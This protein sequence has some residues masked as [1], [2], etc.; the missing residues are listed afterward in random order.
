M[1]MFATPCIYLPADA[2]GPTAR[3]WLPLNPAYGLI[4]NFRATV[5]GSELDPAALATS[6][7][8]GLALLAA[9]LWYFRRV[10]HAL[11]DTI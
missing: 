8:V 3:Q 7:A 4:L 2:I 5:L 10:E 9:G 6:A 11:A 1:W